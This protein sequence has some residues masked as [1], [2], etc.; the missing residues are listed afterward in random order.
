LS[1]RTRVQ[2]CGRLAVEREGLRVETRLPGRKGACA[3]GYLAANLDR[4]IVRDEL[5]FALWGD[6]AP[7]DAEGA[8]ASL[9]SKVR[10]VV[11]QDHIAGRSTVRFIAADDTLIDLHFA[12]ECLHRAQVE[13]AAGRAQLAWQPAHTAFSIARRTFLLGHEAPWIDEWRNRLDEVELWG[14]ECHTEAMLA[15]GELLEAERVARDLVQR[16]P[17]R[18]SGHRLLMSALERG[19]NRAEALRVYERL[20]TLLATELGAYPGPE[21]AAV[22]QR[23]L[24]A[25]R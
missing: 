7:P 19:G 25:S 18:E 3:L 13:L 6:A 23:L 21:V 1:W 15:A 4:W 20:R 11:G 8:L 9:L 16:A 24:R 5:I 22:H 17:F 12:I 14:L 2:L 10:R